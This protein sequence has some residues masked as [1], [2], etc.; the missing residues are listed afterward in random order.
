MEQ[1]VVNGEDY[2]R[3]QGVSEA[4]YHFVCYAYRKLHQWCYHKSVVT[5]VFSASGSKGVGTLI[6]V[7]LLKRTS[8]GVG[9]VVITSAKRLCSFLMILFCQYLKVARVRL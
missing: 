9:F 8:N 2:G 7:P 5:K 6:E 3:I 1:E 4:F